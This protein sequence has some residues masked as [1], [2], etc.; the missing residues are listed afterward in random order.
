MNIKYWWRW[1]KNRDLRKRRGIYLC[2][3][4]GIFMFL[5]PNVSKLVLLIKDSHSVRYP[6]ATQKCC[7]DFSWKLTKWSMLLHAENICKKKV[8]LLKEWLFAHLRRKE[9]YFS[10]D[11]SMVILLFSQMDETSSWTT[12]WIKLPTIY[13]DNVYSSTCTYP[14]QNCSNINKYMEI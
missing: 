5:I 4:C 10:M 13:D 1:L 11:L 12:D 14:S 6:R 2:S 9:Y 3:K 7:V 8:E